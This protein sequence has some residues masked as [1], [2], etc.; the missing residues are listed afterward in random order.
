MKFEAEPPET[1]VQVDGLNTPFR[2]GTTQSIDLSAAVRVIWSAP[3]FQSLEKTYNPVNVVSVKRFD[4][5]RVVGRKRLREEQT[6]DKGPA[7]SVTSSAR[8]VSHRAADKS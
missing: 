4:D 2:Q 1:Q 7:K 5:A 8:K 3:G 6:P